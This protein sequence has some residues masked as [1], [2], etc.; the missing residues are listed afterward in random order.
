MPLPTDE[1]ALALSRSSITNALLQIS[2]NYAH[3][4]CGVEPY[5]CL[6]VR[7]LTPTQALR[8]SPF[9]KFLIIQAGRVNLR[10][11]TKLAV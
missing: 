11:G 6:D 2:L 1:K 9:H 4:T 5:F 10:P 7:D 8:H 3:L